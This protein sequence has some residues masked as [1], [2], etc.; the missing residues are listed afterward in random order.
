MRIVSWRKI[1]S[2]RIKSMDLW[3]WSFSFHSMHGFVQKSSEKKKS[4]LWR[5]T[6]HDSSKSISWSH[7]NSEISR[8]S[9][10]RTS[11]NTHSILSI[12]KI[13]I[14][15]LVNNTV[16]FLWKNIFSFSYSSSRFLYLHEQIRIGSVQIIDYGDVR[17]S[18]FQWIILDSQYRRHFLGKSQKKCRL[19]VKLL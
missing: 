5:I 15:D 3:S 11:A 10:S 19:Q 13:L 9:L 4:F 6:I 16:T 17:K 1:S 8:V 2:L 7:S 14:S 18:V 12:G